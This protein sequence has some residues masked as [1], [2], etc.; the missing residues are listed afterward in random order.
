MPVFCYH[1][2]VVGHVADDCAEAPPVGIPTASSSEV[3]HGSPIGV[4]VKPLVTG[5]VGNAT[6]E[7]QCPV[8]SEVNHTQ[9]T[10]DEMR[11]GPWM[12]DQG[13]RGSARGRKSEAGRGRYLLAANA[14][15][16]ARPS[17]RTFAAEAHVHGQQLPSSSNNKHVT[18]QPPEV[19]PDN[20]QVDTQNAAQPMDASQQVNP[21]RGRDVEQSRRDDQLHGVITLPPDVSV[22]DC[23]VDTQNSDLPMDASQQVNPI[24]GRVVVRSSRGDQIRGGDDNKL[25][26]FVKNRSSR[27]R[28]TEGSKGLR[29]RSRSNHRQERGQD[30]SSPIRSYLPGPNRKSDKYR[31]AS[32]R[33]QSPED[34]GETRGNLLLISSLDDD[35][36]D[37]GPR[38]RTTHNKLKGKGIALNPSSI[39]HDNLVRRISAALTDGKSEKLTIK[40]KIEEDEPPDRGGQP[41]EERPVVNMEGVEVNPMEKS[42]RVR[43]II[44]KPEPQN[45][46][47]ICL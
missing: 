26:T 3:S 43:N 18:T 1:C 28:S 24:R 29:A 7:K 41:Q 36:E 37:R 20:C 10:N 42:L 39:Q 34:Q 35:D 23:H 47:N 38:P 46:K 25:L 27:G 40:D 12:V 14:E 16:S 33:N 6:G 45:P 31:E 13:R 44:G 8:I 11:L 19:L 22:D 17:G 21:V 32:Q 5:D 15:V 9:V 2:G 4:P 30:D